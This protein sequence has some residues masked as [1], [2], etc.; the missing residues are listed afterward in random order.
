MDSQLIPAKRC[1]RT[2]VISR[3]AL[4]LLEAIDGDVVYEEMFPLVVEMAKELRKQSFVPCERIVG[5]F[6][7]KGTEENNNLQYL[8]YSFHRKTLRALILGTIPHDVPEMNSSNREYLYPAQGAGAYLAGMSIEGRDGAFLS[9]NEIEEVIET[10]KLYREG[11]EAFELLA[12]ADELDYGGSQLEDEDRLRLT[13]ALSLDNTFLPDHRR[14]REGQDFTQPA[15]MAGKGV[16]T[17]KLLERQ[18]QKRLR[19][20]D[21]DPDVYQF[22]SPA[23]VGCSDTIATRMAQHD[24][25][26]SSMHC[27]SMIRKLLMA[28]IRQL[29]LRVVMRSYPILL[30]WKPSQVRL[31]E[32]LVT[33]LSRSLISAAGLNVIQPGTSRIPRN[34]SLE[35]YED[36]E[37]LVIVGREWLNDNVDASR[38]Y[39]ATKPLY[40]E[41]WQRAQARWT[42]E[43]A[44]Q[45]VA[46]IN[47]LEDK[48]WRLK[49]LIERLIEERHNRIA[50]HERRIRE[51]DILIHARY[52]LPESNPPQGGE[53]EEN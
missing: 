4:D 14:W 40:E 44:E 41:F 28:S 30:A 20:K 48:F 26:S 10:L 42:A 53:E 45:M 38:L 19:Y 34:Q 36:N 52:L 15:G 39:R 50:E 37:M 25:S 11:C 8:F 22:S 47:R 51:F 32:V 9:C 46:E 6:E 29:G 31:A 3:A 49:P 23:Y 27:T 5:L 43:E 12:Q 1:A 24:P 18:L 21:T 35:R 33:V 17:I 7:A 16:A 2:P 13:F